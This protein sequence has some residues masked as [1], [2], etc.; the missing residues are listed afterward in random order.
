MIKKVII[1]YLYCL[2]QLDALNGNSW[3]LEADR[4]RSMAA[5]ERSSAARA[6]RDRQQRAQKDL[7]TSTFFLLKTKIDTNHPTH[8][9]CKRILLCFYIAVAECLSKIS[10]LEMEVT[11]KEEANA[12]L[13]AAHIEEVTVLANDIKGLKVSI[14][15]IVHVL[16]C[17]LSLPLQSFYST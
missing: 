7:D 13:Q 5:A 16:T 17:K 2:F 6:D 10:E 9:P 3:K 1:I 4:W 8:N 14:T 15:W 12:R 11:S